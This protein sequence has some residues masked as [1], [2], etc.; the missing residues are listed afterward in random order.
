[1]IDQSVPK[2]RVKMQRLT[3]AV[4]AVLITSNALAQGPDS[5]R[6]QEMGDIK[7]QITRCGET[8]QG[9]LVYAPGTSF[10]A[11][12]DSAGNFR[13]SYAQV[14]TYDLRV[15]YDGTTLGVIEQVSVVRKQTTD[16]GSRDYCPDLDNDGFVPPE[17]CDDSNPGINPAAADVCGDGIDNNCNGTTDENCQV[18]TDNDGDGYCA[19]AGCGTP[20]DCVDTESSINPQAFEVCDDIDNDCDGETDEPGSIGEATSYPDWDHDG[21]GDTGSALT[22]CDPPVEYVSIGGDCDDG[23]ATIHPGA[24]EVCNGF[25]DDCDG[26]TDDLADLIYPHALLTCESG[27]SVLVCDP[28]YFDCDGDT[29]D[30]CESDLVCP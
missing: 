13:I 23:D 4:G 18:C 3:V 11:R 2:G 16:V 21:Y 20:V 30:G 19:Q 24:P 17:D 9:A 26:D 5:D 10:D 28:G 8:A 6:V 25:D 22:T 1:L 7:G 27:S 15:T 14:G 12:T 29:E